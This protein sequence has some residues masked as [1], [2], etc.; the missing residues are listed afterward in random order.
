MKDIDEIRRE[1]MRLLEVELGGPAEAA[2][3]VGMSPAQFTNLKKGAKD[4]KTGKRRGMRK[5]TARRLEEAAGKPV[6]WLD[7]DHSSPTPNEQ[8]LGV[9]INELFAHAL[10]EQQ[11]VVRYIL[12]HSNDKIPE[13]VDSDARAYADS[14][15]SKARRW[16]T[17]KGSRQEP[18]KNKA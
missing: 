12:R 4:S 8:S 17:E 5:G 3:R 7:I 14:L 11:A 16:L 10:P 13:W 18:R 6:G 1:N 15:E 2:S 9:D